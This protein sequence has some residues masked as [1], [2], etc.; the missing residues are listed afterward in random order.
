MRQL[1]GFNT[2]GGY[3]YQRYKFRY[4]S[5]HVALLL[6]YW[7]MACHLAYMLITGNGGRD[8]AGA[9]EIAGYYY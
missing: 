7:R 1:T 8:Y 5:R 6:C 9:D 3:Q 2:D 4:R